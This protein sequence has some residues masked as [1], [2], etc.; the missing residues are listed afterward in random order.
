[1]RVPCYKG[2]SCNW[3]A[4]DL[5]CKGRIINITKSYDAEPK[6]HKIIW[7]AAIEAAIEKIRY[8]FV[9]PA[10]IIKMLKELKK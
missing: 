1:M 8:E 10:V 2:I 3:P 6:Q 9:A 4:C 5:F 7:N